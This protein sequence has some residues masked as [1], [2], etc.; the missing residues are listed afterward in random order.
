MKLSIFFGWYDSWWGVYYDVESWTF[1]ICPRFRRCA[2]KSS[3]NSALCRTSRGV[4]ARANGS[5][6][7]KY[8]KSY[9]YRSGFTQIRDSSPY[10]EGICRLKN[11]LAFCTEL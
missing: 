4:G 3:P 10:L 9:T 1:Y 5:E 2:S 11:V 8:K 7:A 6:V